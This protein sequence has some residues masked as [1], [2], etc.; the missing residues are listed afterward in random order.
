MKNNYSYID[1]FAGAGGLTIG[2]G[3]KGFHLEI[4]N[5]I[6]EPALNTLRSNL[7]YTHPKTDEK[8]V[9]LGDI[10]ELYE[11]LENGIVTYDVQGHMVI[12]TNKEVELRKKAPS[13][14]DND[15]LKKI[16]SK[17]SYVDVLVG[18]PPCQGFSMIGRSKKATLE[19]RTKGFIDDPR[20]QLFKYYLKFAE[21]LSPKLVLI[22]NVKGLASASAYKELIE[23]SLK[24]TGKYGYDTSSCILNAKDFGLAQSRERIF[25]IGIRKD[26]SEKYKINASDIFDEISKSKKES[27]KLKDI[28]FDLPQIN[29]NPKPNN[30]KE[31]AEISFNQTRTCFGKN[32]SEIAYK[33][34][35]N[36]NE[37]NEYLDLINTYNGRLITPK[38]LFNHKSRYHNKRDLFIYKNLVPGKYLNDPVNKKA[39]SK[40]TYGVFMDEKGNK[41]VK[42]FGDKYFK[43]N[44]ESVSKTI[45]AHL[46]T[47]GNSYVHPG[48]NPRSITPREAARIQSFPDWY[49]FTGSTRNQFKQIGN[50]VPPILGSLFAEKFKNVLNFIER[51]AR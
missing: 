7:R 4:A 34:L 17:L 50:A 31:E 5:D 1:L 48:E 30:Y 6:S 35:L 12:E 47:D 49:F 40:V 29:A 15:N 41:K 27:L 38:Y 19:D 25:F 18:G 42:G 20:N 8:K 36:K 51:N 11:H 46:E 9:I 2:F 21:K 37:S 26:L 28:I 13:V 10:K 45:I 33:D 22:E 43:L 3:N 24:D 16:V 23:E 44:P 32:I 39:L 14:K